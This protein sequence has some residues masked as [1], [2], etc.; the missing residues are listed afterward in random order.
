MG[1]HQ[2]LALVKQLPFVEQLTVAEAILHSILQQQR[3]H[4]YADEE[5]ARLS[6]A[7]EAL[8]ADYEKDEELTAF[9]QLDG[10]GIYEE[11]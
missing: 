10:E 1:V 4:T 9:T 11:K 8:F 3:D 6:I 7:A 5:D 2:I